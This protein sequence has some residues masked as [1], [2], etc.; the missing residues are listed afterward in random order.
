MTPQEH[1]TSDQRAGTGGAQAIDGRH[2]HPRRCT[3]PG[4]AMAIG[5][6]NDTVPVIARLSYRTIEP[7]RQTPFD[8]LAYR[9]GR[10]ASL[11]PLASP[12]EPCARLTRCGN[13]S[14][15][16]AP[17]QPAGRATAATSGRR[18]PSA[19]AALKPLNPPG[20]HHV[21]LVPAP[22]HPHHASGGAGRARHRALRQACGPMAGSMANQRSDKRVAKPACLATSIF[23]TRGDRVQ[24][25]HAV[26]PV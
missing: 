17:P 6:R 9:A 15:A 11:A 23:Q 10:G 1:N 3:K 20:H 26:G 18:Q 14:S 2:L 22:L 5:P 21:F 12:P 16:S 7:G 19:S 8:C 24:E 25:F 13:A 4:L